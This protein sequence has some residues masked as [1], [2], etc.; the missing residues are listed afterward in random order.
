MTGGRSLFA[1][2][3]VVVLLGGAILPLVILAVISFWSVDFDAFELVPGFGLAS[4]REV[5]GSSTYPTLI[6]KSVLTG[7]ATAGLTALAGYPVALSL[8]RLPKRWKSVALVV[9][10]TPLYTGEIVRIYAWRLVLGTDGLVNGLLMG[11]HLV[12]APLKFILFSPVATVLAL[13][14]DE[15]PFMTL[16]L[17]IA[18]ERLDGRLAEA[19]RDLGA[20][21]LTAFLR[22]TLPLTRTGLCA[23]ALAV[24][25]LSAGDLQTPNFLGGPSGATALA[26]IDNLFGTAFDWPTASALALALLFA[27]TVSAALLAM[28][29]LRLGGAVR[30]R[31]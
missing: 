28:A 7:F 31:P 15:L 25:A 22:V 2:P 30:V 4:W 9:L 12:Q 24:F 23:G 1:M 14:Y 8:L 26:S 10:M 27:L 17:W 13:V 18:A 19:A 6:G 21:P 11:L 5:L 3:L 20:R 16:A 29:I